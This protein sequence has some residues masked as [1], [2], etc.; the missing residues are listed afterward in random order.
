MDFVPLCEKLR[1][2]YNNTLQLNWKVGHG[3]PLTSVAS[4]L[5]ISS[6]TSN[7]ANI[8]QS[9]ALT[10]VMSSINRQANMEVTKKVNKK[11]NGKRSI[12]NANPEN[13]NL[14]MVNSTSRAG[15]T[16]AAPGN[17][18]LSENISTSQV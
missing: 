16:V 7:G 14:R 11:M 4:N 12:G 13:K 2:M 3:L 17:V 18:T 8:S 10:N 5:N 15:N 6:T 1:K 9:S